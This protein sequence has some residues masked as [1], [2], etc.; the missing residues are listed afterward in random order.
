MLLGVV[1]VDDDSALDVH[2]DAGVEGGMVVDMV[3][4]L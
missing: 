2:N 1:E 4:V 3:L